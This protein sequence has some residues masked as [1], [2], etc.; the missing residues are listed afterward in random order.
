[1][2]PITR[3]R[4]SAINREFYERFGESFSA[5]RQRLQ[6]G[7][8]RILE[9]LAGDENILDLG[10]GNGQVARTLARMGHRGKYVGLDFSATMIREAKATKKGIPAEFIQADL[11]QL[12]ASNQRISLDGEPL[13]GKKGWP[14]ILAFAVLHHIP[15]RD[16]RLQVLN[17]IHG[18]MAQEGRFIHSN[19]Q[20]LNSERLKARIQTWDR[21]GLS[22]TEVDANDYLLDWKR[23]G[24]GLRYVHYFSEAELSQLAA[25]TSFKMYESFYSDGDGGKLGLYQ[26]WQVDPQRRLL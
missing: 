15:G 11:T 21:V 18:C 20:F 8:K 7:V 17:Y 9:K 13:N 2:N 12:A 19:W 22:P 25:Q 26:I 3:E 14:V 4:L 5:T 6:P 23:G 1:M 10:C 16:L 24:T